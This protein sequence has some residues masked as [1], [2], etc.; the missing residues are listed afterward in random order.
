MVNLSNSRLAHPDLQSSRIKKDEADIKSLIDVMENKWINPIDPEE[1][2]LV[3]I[4]N[5]SIPP[6][7]VVKDLLRAQEVGEKA[8]Q[9]FKEQ[10][11]SIDPPIVSFF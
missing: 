6:A 2:D 9:T 4:S 7:D 1:S 8:Y 3:C 5:G 11:L 10:R